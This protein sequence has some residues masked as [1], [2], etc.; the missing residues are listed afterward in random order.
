MAN[1]PNLANYELIEHELADGAIVYCLS[2][3]TASKDFI[4]KWMTNEKQQ[5]SYDNLIAVVIRIIERGAASMS[6]SQKLRCIDAPLG[7]YEI[8]NFYKARRVMAVIRGEVVMLFEY[9]A[10]KGGN[11]KNDRKMMKRARQQAK[12]ACALIERE[13]GEKYGN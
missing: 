2:R 11:K 8:K 7:L 1:E 4:D 13:F 12:I 3:T 10:H 9:E 6:N 5:E